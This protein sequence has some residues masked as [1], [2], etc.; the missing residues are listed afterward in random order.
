MHKVHHEVRRPLTHRMG[1]IRLLGMQREDWEP[2]FGW[3]TLKKKKHFPL[4]CI[5]QIFIEPQRLD[6][7]WPELL[8]RSPTPSL[9]ASQWSLP[10]LAITPGG[11]PHRPGSG[12]GV[13]QTQSYSL[14]PLLSARMPPFFHTSPLPNECHLSTDLHSWWV[15]KSREE[16]DQV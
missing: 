8:P 11:A 13:T 4:R 3:Y 9:G 1:F 15:H 12:W 6:S 14:S 10:S 7:Q 16:D 2:S 5:Q